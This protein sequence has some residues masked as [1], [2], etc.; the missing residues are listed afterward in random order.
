MTTSPTATSIWQLPPT[1]GPLGAGDGADARVEGDVP[2][3]ADDLP[4]E[5]DDADADPTEERAEHAV[6]AAKATATITVTAANDDLRNIS[7]IDFRLYQ[8]S[9]DASRPRDHAQNR[10]DVYRPRRDQ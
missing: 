2:P 6:R 3:M 8:P 9:A 4:P 10:N 7:A 1:H 5:L